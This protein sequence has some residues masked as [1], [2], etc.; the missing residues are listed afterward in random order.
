MTKN[1]YIDAMKSELYRSRELRGRI[2]NVKFELN[3]ME[4]VDRAERLETTEEIADYINSLRLGNSILDREA[5]DLESRM[6]EEIKRK[7]RRK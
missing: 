4:S 6:R 5:R 7:H 3:F 2:S 1:D